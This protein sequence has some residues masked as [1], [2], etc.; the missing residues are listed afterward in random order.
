[1]PG[2]KGFFASLFDF[3]FD[4]LV[5]PRLAKV[6]Y[7]ITVVALSFGY[8]LIAWSL[9]HTG[10]SGGAEFNFQAGTSTLT[11]SHSSHAA[12]W[13]WLLIIGPLLFILYTLVYRIFCEVVIVLFQI[14][15]NTR[16][17]LA[18]TRLQQPE[19]TGQIDSHFYL[20]GRHSRSFPGTTQPG[21]QQQP[22]PGAGP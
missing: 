12:A 5:A 9:F 16:D 1:M 21:P 8:V 15:D 18:F 11:A 7:A 13:I 4:A 2:E 22:P 10:G 3:S 20:E 19:L 6:L 17:Q 14:H